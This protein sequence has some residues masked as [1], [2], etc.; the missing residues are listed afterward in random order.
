MPVTTIPFSLPATARSW[1]KTIGASAKD[2]QL[3]NGVYEISN[4][5]Q[6]QS[7]NL[8]CTKRAGSTTGT[9][10]ASG[11]VR[12]KHF[13]SK[14]D[15]LYATSTKLYS[16]VMAL[17]LGTLTAAP[18]PVTNYLCAD[19]VVGGIGVVAFVTSDGAGWYLWSDSYSGGSVP[20][21]DGDTH[22]NTVIDNIF[23]TTGLYPGQA[24]SGSGIVAGTRIATITSSTAITVDTATTATASGVTITR[25]AVAK[26]IDAD[27]PIALGIVE[28]NG[29]FF[30]L[31]STVTTSVR[32]FQSALNNPSSWNS[33][34]IISPDYSGDSADTISKVGNLIMV[35]S[36]N[37]IQY[38]RYGG[39][40]LGS[41]LVAVPEMNTQ[42]LR[43]ASQAIP[44]GNSYY[45]V[46]IP[47]SDPVS[48]PHSYGLYRVNGAEFTKL[49]DD[50]TGSIMGDSL[51]GN[52][53]TADIGNKPIIIVH[54]SDKSAVL[55]YD[56]STEQW[57]ILELSA[58]FT[59]SFADQFTISGQSASRIWS[60]G[61]VWQDSSV[62]FTMTMQT[63]PYY[64]NEGL[65][66]II[67]DIELLA[68][69][70]SSGSTTLTSSADDY[71]TF[72]T[73]G[74]FSLTVQ[75]KRLPCGGYYDSNVA[76]KVADNGNNP[77]R[78]Q[79]LKVRW[80][81]A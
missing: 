58:A 8:Y 72:G 44:Y 14:V 7:R 5:S 43:I 11:I 69:T 38:F 17:E 32:V 61:N 19:L 60:T 24:I 20:T 59:S 55:M 15:Q 81:P 63:E 18:Q 73:I 51:L 31:G 36:T 16:E 3:I 49:S 37:S 27:F 35:G 33:T 10:Y 22:T 46:G 53:S 41:V 45:I 71:A 56:V 9:T 50:I 67:D 74:S 26:I 68:D 66:F 47:W 39:T 65:P 23:S 4:N 30:A 13:N 52:I 21:F 42:G 54:A 77:W 28:L 76:F 79:G 62:A 57:S 40:G 25:E 1:A 78:G 75:Q 29:Y 12:M 34:D 64:L 70:Q 80:R 6:T 48:I 2:Q